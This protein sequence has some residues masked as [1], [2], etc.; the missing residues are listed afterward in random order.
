M[1]HQSKRTLNETQTRL[2]QLYKQGKEPLQG[3][4]L[5]ELSYALRTWHRCEL[6]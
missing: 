5:Y 6:L 4:R 2:H 1:L 3:A